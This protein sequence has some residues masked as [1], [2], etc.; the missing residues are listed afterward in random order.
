MQGAA[1]H[2]TEWV[3]GLQMW[4]VQDPRNDQIADETD[5]MIGLQA[6]WI[7]LYEPVPDSF[8][9]PGSWKP[10]AAY[11]FRNIGIKVLQQ[12]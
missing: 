10:G 11:E 3:N 8:N 12:P 7:S 9:L 1:P 2:I 6:H 4:D 5:G